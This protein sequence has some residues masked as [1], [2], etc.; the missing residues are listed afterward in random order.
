MRTTSSLESVNSVLGRS[1]PAHPHLFKF[2]ECLQLY[3]FSKS[4]DMLEL[5]SSNVP[6]NSNQRK[7]KRDQARNDKI[8][9]F[10]AKLKDEFDVEFG[11]DSFLEAMA[12]KDILLGGSK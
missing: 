1:F 9:F 3:E 2:I 4:L 11:V 7:R 6:E 12:C 8:S 5:V 10:T